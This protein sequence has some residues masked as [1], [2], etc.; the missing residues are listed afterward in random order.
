MIL[1]FEGV[2]MKGEN[3]YS[4]RISWPKNYPFARPIVQFVDAKINKYVVEFVDQW[5]PAL[6]TPHWLMLIMEILNTKKI[7]F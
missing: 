3:E 7:I 2:F 6:S 4:F 1:A 5:S